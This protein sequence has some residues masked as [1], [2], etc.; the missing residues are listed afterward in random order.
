MLKRYSLHAVIITAGVLMLAVPARSQM[1]TEMF[2]YDVPR[3]FTGTGDE[4]WVGS[5]RMLT[6]SYTDTVHVSLD[7]TGTSLLI[8]RVLVN[9]DDTVQ[10]SY[11]RGVISPEPGDT[12]FTIRWIEKTYP[13]ATGH[14]SWDGTQ[15]VIAFDGEW[16]QWFINIREV[17]HDAF[18]A[19]VARKVGAFPAVELMDA[20]YQRLK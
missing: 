3:Y 17:H 14:M 13:E 20:T 11:G 19:A 7:S 4:T 16:R 8:R 5:A 10:V 12:A 15:W 2:H 6:I 9:S 18:E 1:L